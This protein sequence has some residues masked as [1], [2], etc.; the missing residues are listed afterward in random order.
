MIDIRPKT[1]QLLHICVFSKD[2]LLGDCSKA[3]TLLNWQPTYTF[4]VITSPIFHT[5]TQLSKRGWHHHRAISF[6]KRSRAGI[7]AYCK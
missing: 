2:L 1:A 4:P 3:K 6:L 7:G 5:P